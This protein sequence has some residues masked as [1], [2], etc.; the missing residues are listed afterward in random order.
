MRMRSV[1]PFQQL[2]E[3][4]DAV[5][6]TVA[7]ERRRPPARAQAW[8]PPT[9]LAASNEEYIVLV[10]LPGVRRD[11]V[12]A[13]AHEGVV[14]IRGVSAQP[15]EAAD[16]QAVRSERPRGQFVRAVHL[17]R[18]ADMNRISARLAEGV[19]EIRVER[20]RPKSSQVSIEIGQ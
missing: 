14:R 11:Q 2:G 20:R 9:D 16:A 19:L 18:D 8:Q 5:L 13:T 1:S 3:L 7:I 15:E 17:P 6:D 4:R 12:E 10:D